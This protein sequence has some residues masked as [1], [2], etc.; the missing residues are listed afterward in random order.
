[1]ISKPPE[2][3]HVELR[4]KSDVPGMSRVIRSFEVAWSEWA[5]MASANQENQVRFSLAGKVLP[6]EEVGE[7]SLCIVILPTSQ[8]ESNVGREA[9]DAAK[10]AAVKLDPSECGDKAIGHLKFVVKKIDSVRGML[11]ET[12]Q[13]CLISPHN[14]S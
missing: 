13:V 6:L 9:L 14:A 3:V 10:K 11:D 4:H 8:A 1:M 12:S 5:T 7:A 2:K